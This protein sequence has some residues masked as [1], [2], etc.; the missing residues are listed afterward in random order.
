[1]E[2]TVALLGFK[3]PSNCPYGELLDISLRLKF[4]NK[5]NAVILTNQR[6][7]QGMYY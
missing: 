3:D 2:K 4:A 1:M 7:E 6:F 5:V